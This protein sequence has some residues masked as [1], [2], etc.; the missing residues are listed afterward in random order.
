MWIFGDTGVMFGEA[1]PVGT[2]ER[3]ADIR[4]VERRAVARAAVSPSGIG[5]AVADRMPAQ[6]S[7]LPRWRCR[8][9]DGRLFAWLELEI[10]GPA[11]TPSQLEQGVERWAD[12][13]PA[14]DRLLALESLSPVLFPPS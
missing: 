8:L 12:A 2:P 10:A 3:Y 13:L 9:S 7:G 4:L 5:V 1:R 14:E 11:L 6:A